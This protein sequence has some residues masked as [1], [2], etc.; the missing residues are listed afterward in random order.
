MSE[1][2]PEEG[3]EQDCEAV[4]TA[5]PCETYGACNSA[6]KAHLR[7]S[8]LILPSEDTRT[9]V[10]SAMKNHGITRS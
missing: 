8:S 2:D 10:A 1:G 9:N 4:S 3:A 5:P 7:W 6:P